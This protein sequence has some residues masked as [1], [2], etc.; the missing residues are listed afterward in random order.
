MPRHATLC[1]IAGLALI[2]A[3]G[4]LA[5]AAKRAPPAVAAAP[6]PAWPPKMLADAQA[7]PLAGVDS[8][9]FATRGVGKDGHWYA[10][11][12]YWS[13]NEHQ[14]MFGQPLGG[15]LCRLD[16]RSGKVSTILD[17]PAGGIRDPQLSYDAKKILFSYRKGGSLYYHLYEIDLDGSNLRQITDGPRDD[18]EPI[19]LPCGDILFCS[20]RCNRWV[21]CWM[22]QVAIMYRC[23]LDG[24][25]IHPISCNVEQD[26]TPWMMPDGR[27]LYMRWEY[28]DRSRVQFHHLWTANPDGTGAMVYF[29]NMHPGTVM[30]DAKPIPGTNK[31]LSVFS[32]GHGQKEH[33]G[34]LAIVDPDAGPD[35]LKW[36]RFA[37][38]AGNLRDPYPLTK[39]LFLAA[40]G[41]RIVL[42]DSQGRAE[43]IAR[44]G[45]PGMWAHEP[46]PVMARPREPIIAPRT[47]YSQATGRLLLADVTHGRNMAGV[48]QG[49][50]KKLL[51][52]ETL[53]KP[54]NF[55]GTME[56]LSL[57]GTFTLERILGT[58][59]VEPDGSA[60][61]EIPALRPVFFVA[62]DANG[63]SVKRMQ[64]FVSVMP[65]ETTS[66]AGCHE[67]RTDTAASIPAAATLAMRKPPARI[68]PVADVPDVIDFT[69]DVQP[70]LDRNCTRC[71]SSRAKDAPPKLLS[72]DGGRS[73]WYSQSYA[74]LMIRGLVSHGRDAQG[75]IAPRAIGTSASRLMKYLDG[76][77]NNVKLT[78]REYRTVSLWIETGATYPG[79]YA[80]LGTGMIGQVRPDGDVLNR[81]CASCHAPDKG[82]TA[83]PRFRT[84]GELLCNLTEPGRSLILLAPLAKGAG[85]WGI[86]RTEAAPGPVF[87]S[88][89]D[90]DYR[91]LL[92]NIEGARQNL[93]K[94]TRFD[95]PSFR[96]NAP[97]VREMKRYGILPESINPE[98][99]PINVYATD[100]A[101]W[102]SFWF[103]PEKAK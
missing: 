79:T 95:M 59:P 66:C 83:A 13:Q 102:K 65:G 28:V 50:I 98:R 14:M 103:Q 1:N 41:D 43:E 78:P 94:I 26:N 84:D 81:R 18:I 97:Y 73:P 6:P 93:L 61:F 40:E 68:E 88:T 47:D 4:S 76:S 38:N 77:H 39:D 44:T 33:A 87:A 42:I 24:G 58:V 37:G 19:Y 52:I 55:S 67:N 9:V 51:V 32:P 48:A 45:Q 46:R 100:Q 64:S 101:Y 31:V 29:G 85:G 34:R 23:G 80:S 69:R 22:V 27:V 3:A 70:I 2:L 16:L 17:D 49:Q 21:Q 53:P 15:R 71:H 62:L 91:K 57:G 60:Y 86:C 54:V 8:V 5:L 72:L 99:D 90:A 63:M 20:S 75:N 92:A 7:G 30:L 36:V 82:K 89:D 96:P 56:P 11:F 74:A 25:N 12:G 35:E 10:N